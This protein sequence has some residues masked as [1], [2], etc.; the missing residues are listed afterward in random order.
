MITTLPYIDVVQQLP[1]VQPDYNYYSIDLNIES[2]IKQNDNDISNIE[3]MTY[4]NPQA[5]KELSCQHESDCEMRPNDHGSIDLAIDADKSFGDVASYDIISK[6]NSSM[7]T[8][9]APV[10]I[11]DG[12]EKHMESSSLLLQYDVECHHDDFIDKNNERTMA[13]PLEI[14]NTLLNNDDDSFNLSSDMLLC[15]NENNFDMSTNLNSYAIDSDLLKIR[16]PFFRNA[17]I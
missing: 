6:E 14:E 9:F 1:I 13:S 5:K 15:R 16:S 2:I 8:E 7:R 4:N 11:I 3:W 17:I 12:Q 10:D